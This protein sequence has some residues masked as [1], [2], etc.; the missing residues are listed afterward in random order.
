MLLLHMIFWLCTAFVLYTYMLYPLLLA[1]RPRFRR[2][3]DDTKPLPQSV[4]I[5]LAAH[6]EAANVERRLNEL[7]ALLA[8]SGLK[9]EIIVVSDGSTD[10][11]A[12]LARE[13]EECGVR[14]LEFPEKRGKAVAL[15]E[16][17]ALA[18][19]E[20]L[21]FG[22]MRQRWAPDVLGHLLKN[23]ADPTVGGVSGELMVES[24]PGVMAGVALYWRVE[25]WLRK[26]ESR[27][28]SM[29]GATGAISAV[30]RELFRPIPPGTLLDD[31]YW[32]LQVCLQGYR[33][34][35]ES[36]AI[37]FDHLP[38]RP[39]DEFRRKVRTLT[40]NFQLATLVPA[41]LLPWRN[42]I[43]LELVS[44]KMLRLAAPWALLG[45]LFLSAVLPGWLYQVAFSCQVACYTLALLG[46][47]PAI[48]PLRVAST[49]ASFLVL[50]AA[51]WVAFWVWI[52]RRGERAWY[53]VTYGVPPKPASRQ[54]ATVS[55]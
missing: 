3:D 52:T 43:W 45:M 32:P 49:A 20:I 19:Y 38:D 34:V 51:C 47:I 22:D 46:L 50:N 23:F 4:S 11:T 2:A 26:K 39:R 10:D 17:G 33:V 7:T 40:G 27:A 5:I 30:R 21:V 8:A 16:A 42:P 48:Q 12:R 14:V 13:F 6:N 31:V 9:G 37:A 55:T 36:R 35:H 53:K 18:T 54:T 24:A 1:V 41:A 25:K 15:T 29:V 28:Y 44:H